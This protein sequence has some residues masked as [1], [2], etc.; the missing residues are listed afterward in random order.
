MYTPQEWVNFIKRKKIHPY[1][2]R[3]I[4]DLQ[5]HDPGFYEVLMR[6]CDEDF[7]FLRNIMFS[8]EATFQLN[9]YRPQKLNI[10][11]Q[12]IIGP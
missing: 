10:S 2:T 1:K 3:L 9:A 4:H 8:H 11:A 6:R 5:V 12:L 7:S